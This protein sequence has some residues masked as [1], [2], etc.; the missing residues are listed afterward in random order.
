M[1]PV[2][3]QQQPAQPA[4]PAQHGLDKETEQAIRDMIGRTLTP[5]EL[6]V[7]LAQV[8]RT[9]L[10]PLS[11]QIYAV[12]RYDSRLKREVMFVAPTID[13]LRLIAER[14]GKYAGQIGP[15]W[16]GPDGVWK[17]VWLSKNP[18]AAAKVGVIRTDF[19]EPLWAVARWDSYAQYDN[20]GNLFSTWAKMP[21]LM[22]AKCA[23]ALALRKAFPLELSGL[24]VPEEIHA[25]E[26]YEAD[27]ASDVGAEIGVEVRPSVPSP[28]TE[29]EERRRERI[30]KIW[31]TLHVKFG[32]QDK[33]EALWILS[34]ITGKII[35]GSH[36]LSPGDLDRIEK[37]LSEASS[38]EE[39]LPEPN[40][41]E[42]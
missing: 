8:K 17:E 28:A 14:T 9:G 3:M 20:R 24:Y 13:G 16:C 27:A 19:K 37:R 25:A 39:L 1:K 33:A 7:F 42:F 35:E 18:P 29:E 6:R 38:V 23:E 4:Q 22:L 21:D 41:P 36:H 30:R 34:E 11:R 40:L 10:D 31:H 5:A 32:V 26:V 15:F 2:E 12:K